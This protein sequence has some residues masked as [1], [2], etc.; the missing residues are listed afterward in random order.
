[1]RPFWH[2]MASW[3]E[4]PHGSPRS[5]FSTAIIIK[6]Y[7]SLIFVLCPVRMVLETHS[8]NKNDN[9]VCIK[10]SQCNKKTVPKIT[11]LNE[12]LLFII[13]ITMFV[14]TDMLLYYKC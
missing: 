9:N 12:A 8:S 3:A 7:V 1:M 5:F 4:T 11:L 14:Q 13:A 10:V 6:S 2:N